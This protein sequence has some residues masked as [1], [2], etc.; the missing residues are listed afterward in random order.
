MRDNRLN[1]Q[2]YT[3]LFNKYHEGICSEEEAK[4]LMDFLEDPANN[5]FIKIDAYRFW[6]E[7]SD[8][9]YGNN[10]L[11]EMLT[12]LHKRIITNGNG[13]SDAKLINN[14]FL[15]FLLKAAAVLFIPLILYSGYLT[16][17]SLK[18]KN[19]DD[20]AVIQTVRVPSGV[21]TDFT[22][23]DGSHIWLNS[24]SVF[25]YPDRFQGKLREVELIGEGYFDIARDPHHPF[26]VKA[27]ML[28]VE[29][30]GT[31]FDVINYPDDPKIE[32][33]LESGQVSL[34]SGQYEVK[35]TVALI[36]PGERAIYNKT[37]NSAL[38]NKVDAVK[39]TLWKD[40][41]LIFV[42]DP[43]SEVIRMLSHK[44][45]VDIELQSPDISEYVYT[46]TFVDESLI[47]ILDLLK[48]S[49]PLDYT[50]I[51]KKKLNDNSYSRS[52]IIITSKNK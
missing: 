23:S 30:K 16:V 21:Q 31:K 44:Y 39:Y 40:G 2:R 4:E 49:A 32:V 37:L 11:D 19:N 41:I 14:R 46:A 17:K 8:N 1:S 9:V 22:L 6:N 36:R 35:K 20:Q 15:N 5:Q 43:M 45:N 26:I 34:F 42:D 48:I 47:Q 27:G 18:G 3:Y 33:I 25:K 38:V 12:D 28:N 51:E 13:R 7:L 50:V 29:V 10:S 52:K 24:G